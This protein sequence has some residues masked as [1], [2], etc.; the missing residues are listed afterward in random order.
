VTWLF[1]PS[2]PT[3]AIGFGVNESEVIGEKQK[4]SNFA[5]LEVKRVGPF[6]ALIASQPWLGNEGGAV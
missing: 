6:S 1:A 5:T 2:D 3:R 4:A